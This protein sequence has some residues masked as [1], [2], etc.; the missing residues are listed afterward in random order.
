[1]REGNRHHRSDDTRPDSRSRSR[2]RS[3]EDDV[4]RPGVDQTSKRLSACPVDPNPNMSSDQQCAAGEASTLPPLTLG[5]SQVVC[6]QPSTLPWMQKKCRELVHLLPTLAYLRR[7]THMPYLGYVPLLGTSTRHSP[8]T[9]EARLSPQHIHLSAQCLV[10]RLMQ[11][12]GHCLQKVF[13]VTSSALSLSHTTPRLRLQS[14]FSEPIS[15]IV[16]PPGSQFPRLT[17][18][19]HAPAYHTPVFTSRMC[20]LV[21]RSEGCSPCH[22]GC[23]RCHV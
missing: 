11:G 21:G 10:A 2:S 20:R 9:R 23:G 7:S 5:R 15:F 12:L 6:S 8:A 19:S 3:R 1:M 4:D 14:L 22:R 18:P 13:C 17:S 16:Q